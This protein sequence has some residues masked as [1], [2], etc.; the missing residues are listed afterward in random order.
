MTPTVME[1]P[2]VDR[3]R[4]GGSATCVAVCPTQC[5]AM[6]GPTPWL[7]RPG[8]CIS[9]GLCVMICPTGAITL[10]VIDGQHR[11]E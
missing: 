10:R 4:C 11:I 2:E 3:R 7:P 5:L 9:C 1:W 8:D 6:Q